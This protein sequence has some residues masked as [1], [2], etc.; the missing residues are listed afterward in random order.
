MPVPQVVAICFHGAE[1]YSPQ[2]VDLEDVLNP[3]GGGHNEDVGFFA[4]PDLIPYRVDG[5]ALEVCVE[6]EVIKATICEAVAVICG[7]KVSQ[8]LHG[9]LREGERHTFCVLDPGD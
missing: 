2:A 8:W 6:G 4:D 1:G 3:T 7:E 9:W 5:G